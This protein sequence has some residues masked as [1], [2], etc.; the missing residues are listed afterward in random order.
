ML[1]P[2]P[3]SAGIPDGFVEKEKAACVVYV[4]AGSKFLLN[5]HHKDRLQTSVAAAAL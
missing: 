1:K 3:P 5:T 2:A 4:T